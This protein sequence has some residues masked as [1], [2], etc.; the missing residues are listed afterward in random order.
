VSDSAQ[1]SQFLMRLFQKFVEQA[2]LMHQLQRRWMN[3]IPAEITKEI[4]MFFQNDYGH[5][6]PGKQIPSH[7]PGRTAANDHAASLHFISHR[8]RNHITNGD[9]ANWSAA[10]KK[11]PQI[12]Q[13]DA[14]LQKVDRDLANR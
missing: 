1:F 2:E 11:Y 6:R 7:H 9:Y 8:R 5:A 13:I 10:A 14:D 3:G 4:G 12:T